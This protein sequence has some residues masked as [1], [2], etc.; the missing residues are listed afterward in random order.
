MF[1]QSTWPSCSQT[2]SLDLSSLSRSRGRRISQKLIDHTNDRSVIQTF[3]GEIPR[4][5]WDDP[6]YDLGGGG[7]PPGFAASPGF[8]GAAPAGAPGSSAFSGTANTSCSIYES[9]WFA[10]SLRN[11]AI[12]S[13]VTGLALFPHSLRS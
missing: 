8:G 4:S 5:A 3:V 7:L 2:R 12:C 9:G 11:A 1:G 10:S 6:H 13:A